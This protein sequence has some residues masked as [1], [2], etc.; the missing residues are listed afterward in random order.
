LLGLFADE[1]E[2]ADEVSTMAYAARRTDR[3]R[4]T[5]EDDALT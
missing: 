4:T 3:L 5:S 2:L 1:P